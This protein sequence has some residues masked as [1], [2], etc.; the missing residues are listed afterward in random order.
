MKGIK[1]LLNF[2]FSKMQTNDDKILFLN[3]VRKMLFDLSPV[4]NNP[5]DL[6]QWIPFEKLRANEYKPNLS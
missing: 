3:A 1:T 5:V 2:A 4:K 6:V